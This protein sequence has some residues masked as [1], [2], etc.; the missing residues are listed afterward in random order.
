MHLP[1]CIM[2]ATETGRYALLGGGIL[3]AAGTA[4]GLRS[5]RE[6]EIPRVALLSA[7][8]FVATVVP[9]PIGVGTTHPTL[10]ALM[11]LLLGWRAFPAILV[12]GLLQIVFLP[13]VHGITP[14]GLNTCIMAIPAVGCYY[15]F[16]NRLGGAA[17]PNGRDVFLIG[18]IAGATGVL[19]AAIIA[20][21]SL[22]LAGGPIMRLGILFLTVNFGLALVEAILTGS[23]VQLIYRVSPDM[24]LA[25]RS[26]GASK[27]GLELES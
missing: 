24:L 5:M 11:G 15:L 26:S 6:D 14:L 2:A 20:A 17:Q 18:A 4:I 3:A 19:L 16:R 13:G 9:I 22:L 1:E 21:G 8:F 27:I 23:V 12:A 7:A 10:I 25:G